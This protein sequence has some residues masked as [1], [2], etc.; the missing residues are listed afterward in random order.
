MVEYKKKKLILQ[1]GG[2]RNYYYKV[3]SDGK[4]KQVSKNEYLKQK[5]GDPNN[6]NNAN[7]VPPQ[8]ISM[9]TFNANALAKRRANSAETMRLYHEKEK[10]KP[11]FFKKIDDL[12]KEYY[13]GGGY[14]ENYYFLGIMECLKEYYRIKYTNKTLMS[15]QWFYEDAYKYAV[16]ENIA[17]IKQGNQHINWNKFTHEFLRATR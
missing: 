8:S 12:I 7:F 6:P 3:S 13:K 4:K 11:E 17:S 9:N 2:T 1:S 14:G 5:G 15:W 16:K 10:T